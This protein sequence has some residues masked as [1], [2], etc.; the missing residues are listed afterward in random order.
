MTVANALTLTFGR[1]GS[2][3]GVAV[4]VEGPYWDLLGR[5]PYDVLFT[6]FLLISMFVLFC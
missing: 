2:V 1:R 6:G 3:G 5:R 4:E